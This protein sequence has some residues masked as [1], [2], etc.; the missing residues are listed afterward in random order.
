MRP[1]ASRLPRAIVSHLAEHIGLGL[2]LSRGRLNSSL[3]GGC[4]FIGSIIFLSL[5][6]IWRVGGTGDQVP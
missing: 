5:E 4:V 1:P 2:A 6:V 3:Q